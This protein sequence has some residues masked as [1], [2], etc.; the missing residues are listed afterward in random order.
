MKR[1]YWSSFK[2][3]TTTFSI[4]SWDFHKNLIGVDD[5]IDLNIPKEY[6]SLEKYRA[7]LGHKVNHSFTKAN[8]W[9]GSAYHPRFGHV[10]TINAETDIKKGEECLIDYKYSIYA[11]VPEWYKQAYVL[12]V[13]PL[14]SVV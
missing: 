6:W 14:P 7:T 11:N 10:R 5:K 1:K 4:T 12:E 9:F 13:G 8:T 2:R 3:I